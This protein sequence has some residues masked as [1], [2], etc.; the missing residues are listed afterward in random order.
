MNCNK[1]FSQRVDVLCFLPGHLQLPEDLL[2]LHPVQVVVEKGD[3]LDF[4]FP[5]FLLRAA[6]GIN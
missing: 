5:P 2:Q 6:V 4:M 1:E 3:D